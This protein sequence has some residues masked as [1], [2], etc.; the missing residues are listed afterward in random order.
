[1]AS[2]QLFRAQLTRLRRLS[3]PYFLPYT[4]GNAW[5]FILLLM[6]LHAMHPYSYCPSYTAF[7]LYYIFCGL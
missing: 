3:Q 6:S 5:Q 2:L 7:S 1:M 4:D